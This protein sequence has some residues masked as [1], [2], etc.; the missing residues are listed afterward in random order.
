MRILSL[1]AV[2]MLSAAIQPAAGAIALGDLAP[3]FKL[4]GIDDKVHS[5]AD[6]AD[7]K[8]LVICFTS[9]HCP[10]AQAPS[11]SAIATTTPV[12]PASSNIQ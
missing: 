1:L 9:N 11:W 4:T 10:T 6:Y 8:V 5:L 2:M 3:D 7:A 12:T